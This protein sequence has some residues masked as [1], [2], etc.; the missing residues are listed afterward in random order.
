[1]HMSED[2][3]SH[4]VADMTINTFIQLQYSSLIHINNMHVDMYSS[5]LEP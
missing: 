2:T 5:L 3:F 4:V 1:M